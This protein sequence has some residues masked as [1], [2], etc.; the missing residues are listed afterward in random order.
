[1]IAALEQDV[2]PVEPVAVSAEC[3]ASNLKAVDTS[4][5]S[6]LEQDASRPA[7]LAATCPVHCISWSIRKRLIVAVLA[8]AAAMVAGVLMCPQVMQ[9]YQPYYKFLGRMW[10][11]QLLESTAQPRI[12][13][14]YFEMPVEVG[15]IIISA[16]C[17]ISMIC[18]F[19]P[20]RSHIST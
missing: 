13:M 1:M 15:V 19:C 20:K 6:Q 17:L 10:I 9:L 11:W 14:D 12:V 5:I 7:T 8:A 18:G 3:E 16:G 4:L 2:E